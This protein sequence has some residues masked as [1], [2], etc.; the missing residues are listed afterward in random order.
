MSKLA[1][2]IAE[3]ADALGIGTSKLRDKIRKNEI[4]VKYIDSKPVI[5][6][7]ELEAYLASLPSEAP[8]K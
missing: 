2:S 6:T 5:L 8:V 1:H 3:A 4:A 7:T